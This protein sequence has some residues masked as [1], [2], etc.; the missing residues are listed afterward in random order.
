[1][2]TVGCRIT[3][4]ACCLA[5]MAVGNAGAQP[6]QSR[7]TVLAARRDSLERELEKVAVIDRK[8]MVPM[9]DGAKMQF[10]VY[11]PKNT[12]GPVPAIFVRTP[13]NM[14]Y[15]D[16]SLGAPADMTAQ[17]DAVK[18]G[19]AYVGANERG[20]FFSE[21]N[22]D[23][24]G[25][26]LTDGTDEIQWI[27]SQSWSNGKV[28]LIGCSSTAEWQMA[29]AAQSPK[30]LATI[31]PQGFGAGVGRVKPYYEQG[32]WYRGGA[33]QM[34]FI[35]WLAGEQNQVRPMFPA[36]MTQEE[37]VQA[38]K[39][40]DLGERSPPVDWAKAFWHLP[41][42]DLIKATGGPNGIFA[43]SMPVATGG[44]M[45]QRTPNDP[46]WYRGGLFHDDMKINVPGLWFMSWYD[47]S[48]GPNLATYNYVRQTADP[49]IANQ[50][51]AVIAPTL[52]CS[53]K[54]ATENTIVGER[55]VGDAR[56]DYDAL[57]YGWFDFFLK[58]EKNGLLDTLPKIRYYTMGMNKW[59]TTDT[60]P[61]RNSEGMTFYLSSDGGANTRNGNGTLSLKPP[62]SDKPDSFTYD[63]MKPVMSH[64]GN[65][66]CQANALSGGALDQ[67][68]TELRP[69]ILVYTTEPFKEGT[70]LSGPIEATIYLSSDRKD[71]D[72][73]VKII[74]VGPDGKA[75]NLDETIQRVRYREGYD[76][77]PQFMDAGK[78]YKVA[79]QPMTTSNYFAPG[80]RIRIEVSSSNFPRFD[81]NLNTGGNNFDETTGLVAKNTIHHS[82]QYPSSIK[83]TVVK[84][85]PAA[86]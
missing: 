51:Y 71:T 10:D 14:N 50:Q 83:V 24:L 39:S 12:S 35:D 72:V 59:Q 54:R 32:N 78:V 52:H 46:A 25:P 48:V 4:T 49:A 9:R 11:R 76:K 81:R 73:T 80:H 19:Y 66:C 31:I 29:V 20:H 28:G 60:W 53:Y 63:P 64:G 13:Y 7:D 33:V 45:I 82:K 85:N 18:R 2:H 62:T 17:L 77:P 68:E 26:P 79:L 69:D 56:L 6:R 37:L 30:G 22:Y 41:M 8:L 23:I 57:T 15:W 84:K 55:S 67:S 61:P 21:G 58:G 3:I 44:R 27:S 36:N 74:D 86:D 40:Y 42:K 70:E 43:D 16:V 65:V 75:Y 38:A 34:L 5:V 47:V 1:M